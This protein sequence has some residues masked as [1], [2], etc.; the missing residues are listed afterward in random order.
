MQRCVYVGCCSVNGSRT[1]QLHEAAIGC[2]LLF[3]GSQFL[4]AQILILLPPVI[5]LD[6]FDADAVD[7]RHDGGQS[8]GKYS[9]LETA[10]SRGRREYMAG[11]R[12]L[13][14]RLRYR[15][16]NRQP[17]CACSLAAHRQSQ[18]DLEQR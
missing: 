5:F 1:V 15:Y 2:Q 8:G 13:W 17:D 18:G 3:P 16:G 7:A 12:R 6:K 4:R 9:A 14:W 10:P 11:D